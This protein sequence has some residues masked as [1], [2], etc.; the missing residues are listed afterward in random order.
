MAALI[1]ADYSSGRPGGAALAAAGVKV[2]GRY[3]A[4]G[5]TSVNITAAEVRDLR[6]HGIDVFIYNEHEASYMNGGATRAATVAPGARQVCRDAGLPDGPIFYAVDYDATLGGTPTSAAALANMRKLADF[7]T[8][9]AKATS[10][11]EVGVYGGFYVVKWLMDT[12]PDLR[13]AVQTSAWSGGRWDPRAFCRQDAYNWMINGVNCDHLTVVNPDEGSLRYRTGDDSMSAEEVATLKAA[14]DA[15]RAAVGVAVGAVPAAVWNFPVGSAWEDDPAQT[16]GKALRSAQRYAIY[17]GHRGTL[18]GTD[19][20]THAAQLAADVA[21]AATA[22]ALRSVASSAT[23]QRQAIAAQLDPAKFAQAFVD[24]L[25]GAGGTLTQDQVRAAASE[26]FADQL[27]Q[28]RLGVID[29]TG[30]DA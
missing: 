27:A 25:G 11:G 30:K 24:K 9:A 4:A 26:A 18:P 8:G 7:L 3:A 2:V 17:G 22:D 10:W 6:A 21:A 28:V 20:P 16:A 14:I 12:L 23:A 19:T 15:L 13:H 29:T 1:G 5:R